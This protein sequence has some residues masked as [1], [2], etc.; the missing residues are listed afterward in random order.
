MVQEQWFLNSR[1]EDL[2]FSQKWNQDFDD[3]P[4]TKNVPQL[5]WSSEHG[6][7]NH[8]LTQPCTEKRKEEKELRIQPS[9]Q[10]RQNFSPLSFD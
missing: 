9:S 4:A 3:D 5:M 10:R 7:Q 1:A 6:A 8:G 2:Q